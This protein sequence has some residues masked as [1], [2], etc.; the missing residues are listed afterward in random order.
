MNGWGNRMLSAVYSVAEMAA[1]G[2]HLPPDTFTRLMDGGPQLLAPTGTDLAKYG[3][4]VL[5]W[6]LGVGQHAMS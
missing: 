4:W 5:G 6:V 1:C 2:F 3:K